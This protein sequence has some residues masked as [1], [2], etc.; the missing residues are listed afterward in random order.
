MYII[1][2]VSWFERISWFSLRCDAIFNKRIRIQSTQRLKWN[3]ISNGNNPTI[4]S[5]ALN[6][7]A[8]QRDG[9]W[10]EKKYT[11]ERKIE[12]NKSSEKYVVTSQWYYVQSKLV[13]GENSEMVWL[14]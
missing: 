6:N 5:V 11:E 10:T 3:W 2:S 12:E 7:N 4:S 13:V 9:E 1:S 14:Y 8:H